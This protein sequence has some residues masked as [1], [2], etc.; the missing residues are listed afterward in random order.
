MKEKKAIIDLDLSQLEFDL[1]IIEKKIENFQEK[2]V[3][4]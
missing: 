4:R 3:K 1:E 2:K